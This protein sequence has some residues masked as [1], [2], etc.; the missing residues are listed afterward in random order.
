MLVS[1]TLGTIGWFSP[2]DDAEAPRYVAR[3]KLVFLSSKSL[4]MTTVVFSR[5]HFFDH[6]MFFVCRF[7][8]IQGRR[9]V[10]SVL[11]K[12]VSSSLCKRQGPKISAQLLKI[13]P[14]A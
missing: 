3:K 5:Q 8:D 6:H 7:L 12:P 4:G 1:R 9:L 14:T 11:P 13:E 10:L 2:S